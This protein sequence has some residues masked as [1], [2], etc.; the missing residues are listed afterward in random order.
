MSSDIRNKR[1]REPDHLVSS[2][3]GISTHTPPLQDQRR[4]NSLDKHSTCETNF[5]MDDNTDT[6]FN[7]ENIPP[8]NTPKDPTSR[9]SKRLKNRPP[10]QDLQTAPSTLSVRSTS[11]SSENEY[12]CYKPFNP[13]VS[14]GVPKEES[15]SITPVDF[16]PNISRPVNA[17][18]LDTPTPHFSPSVLVQPPT[19]WSSVSYTADLRLSAPF[20]TSKYDHRAAHTVGDDNQAAED[21]LQ[22]THAV[23]DDNQAAHT[24]C[25]DNQAAHAVE[26][27]LQATHTVCD[28]NQ[29]APTVCDDN[30]SIHM[31][32]GGSQAAHTVGNNDQATRAIRYGHQHPHDSDYNRRAI[33]DTADVINRRITYSL[34]KLEKFCGSYDVK[35]GRWE[36][37]WTVL[38]TG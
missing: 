3:G 35:W 18:H 20:D 14:P 28:D 25:D 1:K 36:G 15:R 21:N 7:K 17:P 31:V 38:R 22:A 5:V 32:D 23:C 8:E 24:V 4:P 6:G 10:L 34:A 27:N 26:D 33:H 19:S 11:I 29:A 13:T 12:F 16:Q 2:S 37:C 9:A 30:Q